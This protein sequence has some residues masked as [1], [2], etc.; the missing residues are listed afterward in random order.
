MNRRFAVTLLALSLPGCATLGDLNSLLGGQHPATTAS[1]PTIR[2]IPSRW[3][4]RGRLAA[5]RPHEAWNASFDWQQDGAAY[6]IELQGPLGQG[7][8]RIEGSE[9]QVSIRTADGQSQTSSDPESLL[10]AQLGWR[11]PVGALRYWMAGQPQPG[12]PLADA[13]SDG[14]GRWQS[15]RQ[16]GWLIEYG[17][18]HDAASSDITPGALPRRLRLE[19]DDLS[20]RIVVTRW[21]L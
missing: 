20:V 16:A 8:A 7:A 13:R 5:I 19:Q 4:A 2:A 18:Y 1:P 10:A 14:T 3:Q 12:L 6:R 21:T 15:F 17:D 11:T 9:H